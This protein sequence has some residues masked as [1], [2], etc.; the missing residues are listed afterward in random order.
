MSSVITLTSK[1]QKS[2]KMIELA[3]ALKFLLKSIVPTHT[4][5]QCL[6]LFEAAT[7]AK[8]DCELKA[9]VNSDDRLPCEQ[10]LAGD[11]V[12]TR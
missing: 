6:R 10:S 9:R 4:V 12:L 8:Y 2:A 11:K 5:E 7:F 3:E 1:F